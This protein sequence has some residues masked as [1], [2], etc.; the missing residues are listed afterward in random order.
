MTGHKLDALLKPS[1]IALMGV[2]QSPG[3]PGNT[4]K[5]LLLESDYPGDVY[6]INPRYTTLDNRPCYPDLDT[7]AAQVDHVVI[8]LGNVHLE[9]ALQAC[10]DHGARA[11]TIFSSGVPQQDVEPPLKQ[12]LR[13]MAIENGIVVCGI[14][15]MGFYNPGMDLHAGIFPRPLPIIK[16]GIS[17]ISQ[18]GSA[19]STLCHNGCRLGFNLCVSSGNEMTT[20]VSDYMDWAMEQEDTRVIALFLETIRNPGAFVNALA[21]AARRSIPVVILKIGKSPLAAAMA[22]THTGAIAGDHTVI[23]ALFRRH[24]VIE[25][26]DLD[27]M[28]SVLALVQTGRRPSSGGLA[29]VFESGGFRELVTDRAQELGIE[30]AGLEDTTRQR[31]T[32]NLDSGLI[33][34]NPLDAW[35][36]H[37]RFEQRFQ[38]CLQALMDDRNVGAGVFFTN[39]RDD[40]YLSEAIYRVVENVSQQT[41]KP[42][43]LGTCYSDLA[44]ARISR[45]AHDSGIPLIQGVDQTLIAFQKLMAYQQFSRQR[46]EASPADF[47]P[48]KTHAWK[49]RLS[50]MRSSTPGENESLAMLADFGISVVSNRVIHNESELLHAAGEFGYPL[51]LKTAVPGI[52]HKSDQ[53]GVVLNISREPEL[54]EH[55]RDFNHRLGSEALLSPML[56]NGVEIALGIINDD[57][58]GPVIMVAAGGILIELIEDRQFAMCP[59]NPE[60]ADSMLGSLRV[61]RLL[62]GVR[63]Q[64]ACHRKALIEMVVRLS[65]F[66]CVFSDCIEGLDINPVLVTSEH[67]VA[68]DALVVCR[69]QQVRS[70]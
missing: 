5:N 19:F 11:A 10:V 47:D 3:T 14:N 67:A 68:V 35:G 64:P 31:I 9:R 25:V 53:Q 45:R 18:S 33:A 44:N 29:A 26:D 34:E 61:N 7:L 37:D 60:Q 52:A 23:Q 2:S 12:R 46:S 40:Y 62:E 63:G 50:A 13:K 4:L 30:F 20:D 69:N 58:F 16:G 17:Y 32:N 28:A 51:V 66:A 6:L 39:Y 36:S 70:D 55:Y 24:G 43:A 65:Q 1:R 38:A 57:D 59:V 49:Q 54:L 42:L 41:G 22:V 15:G 8:A 48:D 27:Q 56:K 21:K